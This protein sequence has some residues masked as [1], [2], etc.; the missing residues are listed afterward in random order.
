MKSGAIIVDLAAESGGNCELTRADQEV[1]HGD[2][3]ILGPTDLAAGTP[4]HASQMYSRNIE[5]LVLHIVQDG[6]LK[7]DAEDEIV[8]DCLVTDNGSIVHPRVSATLTEER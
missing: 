8:R 6:E 5:A 3:L 4:I 2:V 1:V 7:L